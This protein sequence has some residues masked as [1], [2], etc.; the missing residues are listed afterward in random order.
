MRISSSIFHSVVIALSLS[1]SSPDLPLLSPS[2]LVSFASPLPWLTPKKSFNHFCV[3]Y[4]GH[5]WQYDEAYGFLFKLVFL[6]K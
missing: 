5:F 1:P 3:C 2:S 4:N 6:N